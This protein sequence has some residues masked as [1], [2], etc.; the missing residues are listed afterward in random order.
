MTRF[1][2]W[3]REDAGGPPDPNCP[4]VHA[5]KA[6]DCFERATANLTAQLEEVAK[7]Y[8][9]WE[10][11]MVLDSGAWRGDDGLPHLTQHLQDKLTVLQEKRNAALAACKEFMERYE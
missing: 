3:I 7:G 8:E 11:D 4:A 10:A 2:D 5:R 6:C 1:G 9:Q